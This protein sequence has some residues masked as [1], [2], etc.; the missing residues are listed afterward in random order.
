MTSLTIP[1]WLTGKVEVTDDG[2]WNWLMSMKPNGYGQWS[3][4]RN[5]GMSGLAHRAVYSIAIGP[6]AAD[7]DI[8]H[9]CR[10]RRCV[11]PTHLEPVTR[12]ENLLRSPLFNQWRTH[13]THCKHGHEL[14]GDNLYLDPRNGNRNCKTCRNIRSAEYKARKRAA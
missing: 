7:L 8:D 6:V 12:R 2:C 5:R 11:N 3:G 9:L 4:A 14:A 10:N 1:D 13:L